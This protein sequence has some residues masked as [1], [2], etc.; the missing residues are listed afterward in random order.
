MSPYLHFTFFV[1]SSH[2]KAFSYAA[3]PRN[4]CVLKSEADD[5]IFCG[6]GEWKNEALN[7]DLLN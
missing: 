2:L 6:A 5:G 3:K 1:N 4:D 7:R